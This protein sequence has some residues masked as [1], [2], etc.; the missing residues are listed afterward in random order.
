MSGIVDGL[1]GL[2][3]RLH[4]NEGLRPILSLVII[5]AIVFGLIGAGL[6]GAL[7]A[8]WISRNT[9]AFWL[10][11]SPW[12]V[13][14]V[15]FTGGPMVYSLVLSF[16]DWDLIDPAKFTGLANYKEALSDP[17]L[18]QAIKVTLTY[19]VVSV[20]LQTVLSLGV[21]LLM[22][23]RVRGV[24]VFRTIWYL[25]SLVTG[26]AQAVLFIWVFHPSYGLVNGLL[27]LFGV[28]GPKW[29]FDADW[30]LP[31]VIL[32]SLWTVGGNMII[33]LAGLQDV[34]KSL[35]EAAS[36]D[37]AGRWHSLWH[38]TLPQVSPVIFFNVVTGLIGAMQ[39]FTQGYVVTHNGGGPSDS[40]LFY[41]LYLYQNAFSFFQ[42]GYAS[43]L[44][45]I[46]FGMIMVLT[47]L[48]F[49]GSAFWV[50][51]ES[52]RPKE[53]RRRVHVS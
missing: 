25:P 26:V 18:G 31:A 27:R 1:A 50:Y 6:W 37:G 49:R 5:L 7:R 48:V 52:Q 44:A 12:I 14:F 47:A 23:V 41:V 3:E 45:W 32:M 17:K 13:G 43:A 9:A 39:T 51:Y 53:R 15:I 16:M 22:N 2:L 33:Y 36:I 35:Y 46:L 29:L 19:A 11:V 38:I 34:P 42:M 30:A 24:N 40:L 21:A 8:R 20:P 28:D 4:V 10:F